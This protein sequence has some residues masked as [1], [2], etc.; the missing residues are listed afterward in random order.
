MK[1]LL[2]EMEEGI[3]Y[4]SCYSHN[5]NKYQLALLELLSYS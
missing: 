4:V 2:Q 5:H 3:S 1:L